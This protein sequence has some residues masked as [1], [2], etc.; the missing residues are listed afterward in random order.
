MPT[1]PSGDNHHRGQQGLARQFLLLH[2]Q[3]G[4][5][6]SRGFRLI[7]RVRLHQIVYRRTSLDVPRSPFLS[8]FRMPLSQTTTSQALRLRTSPTQA[9]LPH[10][11]STSHGLLLVHPYTTSLPIPRFDIN[12]RLAPHWSCKNTG[13]GSIHKGFSSP[14]YPRRRWQSTLQWRI[15]ISPR[16]RLRH[17]QRCNTRLAVNI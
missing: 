13:R 12:P 4:A 8:V 9:L 7:V 2:R 16:R 6:G 1:P 17:R 15:T 11:L 14:L 3:T 10:P 5:R